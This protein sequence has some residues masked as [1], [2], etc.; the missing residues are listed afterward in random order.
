MTVFSRVIFLQGS[1]H[2]W[3]VQLQ[4]GVQWDRWPSHGVPGCRLLFSGSHLHFIFPASNLC[5]HRSLSL[6]FLGEYKDTSYIESNEEFDWII[7]TSISC[8]T[9]L[10]LVFFLIEIIK[11]FLQIMIIMSFKEICSELDCILKKKYKEFWFFMKFWTGWILGW[12]FLLY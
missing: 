2:L 6:L 9:R 5:R 11:F 8:Q 1:R 3:K 10:I 7:F 4:C 12:I